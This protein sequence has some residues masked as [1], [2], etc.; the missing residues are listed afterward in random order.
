MPQPSQRKTGMD[1]LPDED[2]LEAIHNVIEGIMSLRHVAKITGISRTV[3][4]TYVKKYKEDSGSALLNYKQRCVFTKQQ[5]LNLAEHLAL[6][7]TLHG[8]TQKDATTLVFEI[9]D[10]NGFKMP[11]KWMENKCTTEFWLS[12][13]LRRHPQLVVQCNETTS[14][15]ASTAFH[16]ETVSA[17][18]DILEKS[19]NDY[20]IEGSDIY[21]LSEAGFSTTQNVPKGT[22]YKGVSQVG[23]VVCRKREELVTVCA[24]TSAAGVALP[25]VIVFPCTNFQDIMLQG[26]P[27]GSLGFVHESE[28]MNN[29]F[30]IKVLN[31]VIEYANASKEKPIILT[32]DKHE[33]NISSCAL[34]Y[35]KNHG[36]HVLT[37]PQHTSQLTQPF[38]HAV[39]EPMKMFFDMAADS[40][41][42]ANPGNIVTIYQMAP[43]IGFAWIK[44][45]TPMNIMNGFKLAGIWPFD[46]NICEQESVIL[47]AVTDRP[48]LET[49]VQQTSDKT[50]NCST[51]LSPGGNTTCPIAVTTA[52]PYASEASNSLYCPR[53][54]DIAPLPDLRNSVSSAA[55]LA[56]FIAPDRIR[57]YSK[58][59]MPL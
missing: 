45:A 5:E 23:Q 52:R 20:M 36:V 13:F 43:M 15:T 27:D 24:I 41:R 4:A 40:W 48:N 10:K 59:C 32:M 44:A 17:F 57:E 2:L 30:F 16:N 29:E 53:L 26:A 6:S 38:D 14:F 22:N 35:A 8:L 50:S 28:W 47:A 12:G 3:L 31:H 25:P 37:L 19:V 56:Q 39:F 49:C 51:I 11:K 1:L 46:R 21:I 9:A 7:K 54:S 34:L 55:Y 33:S 42:L 58:V 18:F